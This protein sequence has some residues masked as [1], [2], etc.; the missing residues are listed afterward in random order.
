MF[1]EQLPFICINSIKNRSDNSQV[2]LL[3]KGIYI[4]F[5]R[6]YIIGDIW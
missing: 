5:Q 6:C 3:L 1:V 4:L 2:Q